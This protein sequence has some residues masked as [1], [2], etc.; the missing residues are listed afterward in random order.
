MEVRTSWASGEAIV[1]LTD[2]TERLMAEERMRLWASV[3]EQSME[4]IVICDHEKR[5]IAVNP[6]FERVTGFSSQEAVGQTPR[7]LC[8]GRQD[9]SFYANMWRESQALVNGM[10]KSGIGARTVSCTSSGWR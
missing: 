6:A 5:I 8:S 3:L 9:E 4:G 7:I 1:I 10:V 2:I